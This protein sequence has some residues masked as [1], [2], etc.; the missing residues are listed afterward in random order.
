M[1]AALAQG[2]RRSGPPPGL[3]I[4]ETVIR[5]LYPVHVE[6]LEAEAD[7][8]AA[9][10]TLKALRAIRSTS[11]RFESTLAMTLREVGREHRYVPWAA[12]TPFLDRIRNEGITWP[13]SASGIWAGFEE[14]DPPVQGNSDTGH[15]QI[16]NLTMAPQTPLEITLAINDGSFFKNEAL[17]ATLDSRGEKAAVNFSFMLSGTRGDDGRVHSAWN[18]LEAFLELVFTHRRLKP[19]QV[20]MQAIL[21]GRD[22]PARA[23]IEASDGVGDY[24][25]LLERLLDRYG[26]RESL[27]W[28]IGRNIAMD[29]DFREPGARTDYDLLTRGAGKQ[30]DGLAGVRSAIAEAHR[31]GKNDGDVPPIVV[32][33]ASRKPRRVAAGDVFV[34]LHFRSD[35]QRARTGAL[36]GGK[37]YLQA[38]ARAHGKEWTLDWLDPGLKLAVCTLSEYHPVFEQLGARVAYPNRPHAANFLAMWNSWLPGDRYLLVGES[39]KSAHVGYFIRGR[40]ESP[41][42]EVEDRQIFPSCSEPEGV[43][44]DSDFYKTPAMRNEDVAAHIG[45]NLDGRHRLIVANF[46]N[47]DMVGHLLP[48][49]YD[50]AVAALESLERTLSSLVP[51]AIAAGYHVVLT[52]DHGNIEDDTTAHSSN[53]VLTTVLSSSDPFRPHR[54]EKYQARL[55]D[56]PATIGRIFG[57]DREIAAR[58]QDLSP[59]VDRRFEGRPLIAD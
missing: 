32:L 33:D 37:A 56:I 38:A 17:L 25:G 55:F 43:K 54:R 49:R 16:G 15:Q 20:R 4:E 18:H 59:R 9:E 13:T 22:C 47:C 48:Q 30:V 1:R 29:R 6:A 8:A 40:R 27:A 14:L 41:V 21:D 58:L 23:S 31:G 12:S 53:D 52:S 35:R 10:Q 36:L 3:D 26:A 39:V 34:N 45:K 28:V 2:A 51:A 50:A 19:S 11:A 24:L 42:G 57:L 5:S 7:F 44:S 46:S